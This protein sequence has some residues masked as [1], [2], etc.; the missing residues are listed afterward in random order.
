MKVFYL[1]NGAEVEIEKGEAIE[2]GDDR[3]EVKLYMKI[4]ERKR[5][6]DLGERIR[7]TLREFNEVAFACHFLGNQLASKMPN[8]NHDSLSHK[9]NAL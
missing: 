4:E 8:P 3:T 6:L 9:D 5:S 1:R 2:P 7:F